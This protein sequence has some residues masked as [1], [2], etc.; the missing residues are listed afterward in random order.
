MRGV[1]R[2]RD[3]A[4]RFSQRQTV[5]DLEGG[6]PTDV[7]AHCTRRQTIERIGHVSE[8]APQA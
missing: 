4:N 5:T 3:P 6:T 2:E 7:A 1:S 8:H